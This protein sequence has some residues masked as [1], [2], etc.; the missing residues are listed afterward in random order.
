[1][2]WPS[3]LAALGLSI[4]CSLGVWQLQRAEWKGA[5][6]DRVG[7]AVEAAPVPLAQALRAPDPAYAH[8]RLQGRFLHGEERYVFTS[9]DRV[10][11]VL[12]FTPFVPDGQEEGQPVILVNR[13]FVP[14]PLRNPEVRQEGQV[15]APATVTGIL[16]PGE[17][18]GLFV[19]DPQERTRT[20]YAIDLE[21]LAGLGEVS[22]RTDWFVEADESPV[23]GGLP[24]GRDPATIVASIPNNHLSYAATWFSLALVLAG[25]YVAW[26]IREGRLGR[27][28]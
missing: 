23:P 20:A 15:P 4:L 17:S 5:L 28:A 1:M 10:P 19:P 18:S 24:R 21:V 3:V 9:R 7:Q 27:A 6:L 25:V 8:V 16:R 11:G 12:V 26:H 2:L 14:E 13:G 22:V